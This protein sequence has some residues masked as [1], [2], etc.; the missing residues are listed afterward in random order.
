MPES[1]CNPVPSSP[2][3]LAPTPS[4][5]AP[6]RGRVGRNRGLDR[7]LSGTA[8][9][10]CCRIKPPGMNHSTR[11]EIMKRIAVAV[12]FFILGCLS[13]NLQANSL[14][15]AQDRSPK[16]LEQ[17]V[18]MRDSV[19]L[20]TNIYLPDGQG[21]WPVAVERTPYNK[22]VLGGTAGVWTARGYALVI[23]DVRGKFKSEGGYRPF[24]DDVND[25]YDTVEWAAKQA[26]SNGKVGM[27]GASAMGITANLAATAVPPHLV[28]MFTMVARSSIYNQSAFM[29][30]VFRKELNEGWLKREHA[31][32]MIGETLKHNI[33]DHFFD[34]NEMP[35]HWADVRVP[36]YNYGGWYDIFL[37]GNIDDFAG[38]Q[39]RGGGLAAGN[40]KLIMGPWGHGNIEEIKYPAN[41]TINPNDEALRWFDYWLKGMGNG[42]MSEAPI[43]YYVMGDVTDPAAPGNQWRTAL[44]WP[45][46]SRITSYFF[47]PGGGL[48]RKI[49]DGTESKDTYRYDPADPVPTIGG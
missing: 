16:H 19:K 35:L 8:K 7:C 49:P 34:S 43:K 10:Q 46:P 29:G 45:P 21:P 33:K 26:W 32:S 48:G 4:D 15:A 30:G 42:I 36:V 3:I 18:P 44:S 39:S 25:G 40:Q 12:V 6:T 17:M 38:L 31:E 22:D 28:A 1:G 20:G 37:Q 2:D 13:L 5:I 9:W 41:S 24:Q 47:A 27:F 11:G 14:Q 23:Q